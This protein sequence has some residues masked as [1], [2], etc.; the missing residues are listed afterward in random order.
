MDKLLANAIDLVKGSTSQQPVARVTNIFI[1]NDLFG[2][3]KELNYDSVN[4]DV[5]IE[6]KEVNG[7]IG[8]YCNG[9]R[10]YNA[11]EKRDLKGHMA[12]NINMRFGRALFVNGKCVYQ[13]YLSKDRC[14]QI[15]QEL[16][17]KPYLPTEP[18]EEYN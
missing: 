3:I 15:E 6:S 4:R 12:Y 14:D 8:I 7:C 1:D 13:G 2:S 9:D 18:S 11:V 5:H 17:E 16:K 10:R